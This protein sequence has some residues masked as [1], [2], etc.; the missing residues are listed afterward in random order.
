MAE[1]QWDCPAS[2]GVGR[3]DEEHR[4]LHH[5]ITGLLKT[6]E[7]S[8]G[9]ARGE[10]RFMEIFE[11]VVAHFK[12]EED[13]L[14]AQGF[15]GL[16]PHRFEHELLL[17]WFRDQLVLRGSTGARP[18]ILLV[19]EIAEIIQRHHQTVDRAYAVW[20]KDPEAT[21]DSLPTGW[22]RRGPDR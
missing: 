6:L 1:F 22:A 19:R 16:A 14:E 8:P 15:P 3:L 20:L 18:L 4:Q 7:T 10:A 11:R 17:D 21:A 12:T 9:A 5:L 2:V 13:Y